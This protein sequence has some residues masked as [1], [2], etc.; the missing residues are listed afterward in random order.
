MLRLTTAETL[1]FA[2]LEELRVAWEIRL[3]IPGTEGWLLTS[4]R[5]TGRLLVPVWLAMQHSHRP[6][7][8]AT[9]YSDDDGR[10]WHAG[11]LDMGLLTGLWL[12]PA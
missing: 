10:T 12:A 2:R 1:L 8:V 11:A 6:S 4:P 5:Q 9:I 3:R 7:C